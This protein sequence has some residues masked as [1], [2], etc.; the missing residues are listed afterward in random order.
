MRCTRGAVHLSK[1]AGARRDQ[2][3]ELLI[4]KRAAPQDWR[5][6]CDDHPNLLREVLHR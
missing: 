2:D 6:G 5:E 1:V 4:S 3:S